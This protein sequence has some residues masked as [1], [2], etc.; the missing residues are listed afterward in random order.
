MTLE[1]DKIAKR[2]ARICSAEP[3]SPPP[4]LPPLCGPSRDRPKRESVFHLASI[5]AGGDTF[6]R[7]VVSDISDTGACLT[8]NSLQILPES[9]VVKLDMD[10]VRKRVSV[11]WQEEKTI[12]V[13]ISDD[14]TGIDEIC[15]P[16]APIKVV[17]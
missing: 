11:I 15:A 16:G 10:G 6:N 8:L 7:C 2:I 3:V 12:G 1:K 9:V 14:Q 13:A 4:P 5:Y 17:R